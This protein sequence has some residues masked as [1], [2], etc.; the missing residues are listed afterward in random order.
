MI[1]D[2]KELKSHYEKDGWGVQPSGA[3]GRWQVIQP[4]GFA[5]RRFWKNDKLEEAM[6]YA[7]AEMDIAVKQAHKEGALAYLEK[8]KLLDG[9]KVINPYTIR[10]RERRAWGEGYGWASGQLGPAKKAFIAAIDRVAEKLNKE[11]R[12]E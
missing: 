3:M 2:W 12:D 7:E 1:D 10:T 4:D 5:V 6:A 8:A 11:T 9:H